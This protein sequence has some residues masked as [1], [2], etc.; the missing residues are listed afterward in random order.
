MSDN[1]KIVQGTN[2]QVVDVVWFSGTDT[3]G[4]V[5]CKD[6]NLNYVKA[7]IGVG[8]G[9]DEQTDAES[10]TKWGSKVPKAMAE[11]LFGP[12]DNWRD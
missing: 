12:L 7:Y 4:V 8:A 5:L 3:V 10:I 6:A 1:L 2:L 9:Y 11:S